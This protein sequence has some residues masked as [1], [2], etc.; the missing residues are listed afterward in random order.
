MVVL[1]PLIEG[2]AITQKGLL[3][4]IP[5]WAVAGFVF[6]FT[7]KIINRKKKIKTQTE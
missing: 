6:G 4:G 7:M 3:V 1:F 2:E 5:V